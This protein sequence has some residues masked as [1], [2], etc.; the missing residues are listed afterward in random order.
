MTHIYAHRPFTYRA[1]NTLG[2]IVQRFGIEPNFEIGQLLEKAKSAVKLDDFGDDHFI[3]PLERLLHAYEHEAHLNTI[4]KVSAHTYL[5]QLLTNRLRLEED[6][7]T[8]LVI[9]QQEIKKPIFILGL[10]RSG[11]TF[12]HALL[13]EDPSTRTPITWEVMYPSPPPKK[14]SFDNDERIRRTARNLRWLERLAPKFNSIHAVKG[15]LAQ[16]CIAITTHAFAS[17]QFHTTHNVPSYQSW[18]EQSDMSYAYKYHKRF[19]Q[20]LQAYNSADRWLLK[21]PGHM[22]D[23]ESLLREYPDARIIQTHRDPLEVVASIS[24]HAN[25]IRAAFSDVLYPKEIAQDWQQYWWRALQRTMD[26]RRHNPTQAV[27]D[28]YYTD[29]VADPI[30]VVKKIYTE[31]DMVVSDEFERAMRKYIQANAQAKHRYTLQEFGFEPKRIR[32]LFSE[33]Y[34]AYQFDDGLEQTL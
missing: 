9:A 4:G 14:Q 28:I 18:L 29:L 32:E 15:H 11:T 21:A 31:L 33:Y 16:E 10:P 34:Q 27:H 7:K 20:H 24:S 22:F 8:N 25:V 2:A 26:Y 17:I 19:L 13:A 23:I 6:R 1:A 30:A 12:L 3:T 5:L